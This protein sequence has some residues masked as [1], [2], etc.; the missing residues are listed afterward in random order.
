[1]KNS[2]IINT[3]LILSIVFIPAAYLAIA[4]V[5]ITNIFKNDL[6][7]FSKIRSNKLLLSMFIVI[8]IVTFFSELWYVS[9]LFS[10]PILLSLYFSAYISLYIK[11]RNLESVLKV[12]YIVSI[13]VFSIGL[14]QYIS[15]S[16]NIPLKWIDSNNYNITKRIY[17]TFFNPNIY[18]FYISAIMIIS[19]V[20]IENKTKNKTLS[21]ITIIL[22]LMNLIL[23]FS[24]TSWLALCVTF[25]VAGFLLDYKFL[26]YAAIVSISILLFDNILSTG[27]ANPIKAAHDSGFLYRIEIWKASLKI[28]KDYP[29]TGIGFGTLFDYISS[30]SDT[31][32]AYVEHNHNIYIQVAV[33]MGIIGLILAIYTIKRIY[34]FIKRRL[35]NNKHDKIAVITAMIVIMTSIHGIADSIIFTYQMILI[36]AFYGGILI[37]IEGNKS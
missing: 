10:I 33:D 24:R 9:L 35:Q 8:V 3:V 13:A 23:T 14:I 29:I 30:Y 31:I 32:S 27:R 25:V 1:M 34:M 18:G 36:T 2:K 7:V 17:S 6:S 37:G 19:S 16:F 11:E 26:K 20:E 12:I 22:G 5:L 15:P 4:A 21:K 28:F